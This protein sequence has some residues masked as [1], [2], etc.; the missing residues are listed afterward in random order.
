M[1]TARPCRLKNFDYVGFQR[2]FLTF[3]TAFRRPAFSDPAVAATLLMQMRRCATE[4]GFAVL[5]YC[6]MPDHVHLL[7]A[8]VRAD[9]ALRSF[10]TRFKQASGYWYSK[11]N[12]HDLWQRGFYDYVL[13]DQDATGE[14][15]GYILANPVRAGLTA[16]VGEYPFAGS[17]SFDA[18]GIV[19]DGERVR[20]G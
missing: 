6:F 18:A 20:H 19:W 17:D 2:Y 7:V 13:R 14:I 15:A 5:A 3:C 10:V 4:T 9:S 11:V 1:I 12:G 8:G 16:A